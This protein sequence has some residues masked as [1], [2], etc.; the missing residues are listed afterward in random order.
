MCGGKV[1]IMGVGGCGSGFLW[2]LLEDCGL[3]TG[4]TQ[5]WMRHSGIRRAL[6]EGKH[7]EFKYPKVIKHLGGFIVNLNLHVEQNNWKIE[8]IFWAVGSLQKQMRTQR[9]RYKGVSDYDTRLET[10]KKKLGTGLIQLIEGGYPFTI[11]KCPT[12][13]ID[14]EYCWDKL[15]VVLPDMSYEEFAE[16]HKARVDSEKLERLLTAMEN[17]ND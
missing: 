16:I 2:H 3:D 13:L 10:Y 5:E 9:N 7:S 6:R 15:K 11:V 1:L 14:P 17:E 12:S 4:G 8:H